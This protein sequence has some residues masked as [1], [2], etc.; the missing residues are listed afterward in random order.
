MLAIIL[1][2]LLAVSFA[3]DRI[4]NGKEAEPDLNNVVFIVSRY[5]DSSKDF[6]CTGTVISEHYVLTAA[7]CLSPSAKSVEVYARRW[8]FIFL[9]FPNAPSMQADQWIIHPDYK[10]VDTG[11]DIALIRVATP[12]T[13]P[14]VPLAANYSHPKDDW[15]RV[16]GYG[17][18]NYTMINA[19]HYEL[20]NRASSLM[21][22]Y[23]QGADEKDCFNSLF[24]EGRPHLNVICLGKS[25]STI[26]QGDSGGPTFAQGKDGRFYQVGVS[27]FN[28]LMSAL[29]KAITWPLALEQPFTFLS[30]V[31]DVSHY[32]PWI[33]ETTGGEVKCQTFEPTKIVPKF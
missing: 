13:I 23:L 29:F 16:A 32:C 11:D 33:E 27:S 30:G 1:L 3:E 20:T 22:T 4:H 17:A 6:G 9:N 21:E 2:A 14:P 26:L 31:T 7:H 8:F 28:G 5:E 15:L 10:K 25:N 12:M 19:T 18:T 24:L